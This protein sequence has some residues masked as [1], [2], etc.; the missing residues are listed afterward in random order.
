MIC[1]VF[2]I[3]PVCITSVPGTTAREA[4]DKNAETN[5]AAATDYGR[6]SDG[7]VRPTHFFVLATLIAWLLLPL[8][9]LLQQLLLLCC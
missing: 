3:F 8:K 4:N 7:G 2:A 1:D 6:C 5:A 9:S